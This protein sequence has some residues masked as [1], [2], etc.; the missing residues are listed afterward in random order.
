[1]G[2]NKSDPELGLES[3]GGD[4]EA[5]RIR[6][7]YA[8]AVSRDMTSM[9]EGEML[10]WP[11]GQ[12]DDIMMALWFIKNNYKKLI[13]RNYFSGKFQ[14]VKTA[15][16]WSFSGRNTEDERIRLLRKKMKNAR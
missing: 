16:A 15:R 3:L 12:H 4:V 6:T 5:G 14:G 9:L 11:F 7:P 8:D 1:T 13:P 10:V 2:R